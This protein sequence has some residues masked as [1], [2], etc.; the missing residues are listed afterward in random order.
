MVEKAKRKSLE[1]TLLRKMPHSWGI[2]E[3]SATTD[4]KGTSIVILTV[5][6]FSSPMQPVQRVDGSW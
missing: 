6:P 1:V 4:L 2:V 5:T 3:V